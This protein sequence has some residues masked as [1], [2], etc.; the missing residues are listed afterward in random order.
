MKSP[1]PG[2][3]PYL[4]PFWSGVHTRLLV[5]L[6]NQLQGQLPSGLW[7]DVEETVVV[8]TLGNP[9]FHLRPDVAVF[10]AEPWNPDPGSGGT[11]VAVAEPL[12]IRD[13][14]ERT[15]RAIL[16]TDTTTG[17]QLVTAIELLSPAN[18]S[19][20]ENRAR[21]IA[22][23]NSYSAAGANLVEIDLLRGGEH[24]VSVPVGQL[25]LSKRHQPMVCVRRSLPLVWE[26]YP[27]SLR[28][29][30]P[31]FRVPLRRGDRDVI[32]QLQLAFDDNYQHGGYAKR[33]DYR[34]E[35]DPPFSVEDACWAQNLLGERGQP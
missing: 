20:T 29:P 7:A 33:V 1:F 16:V 4:E 2:L 15:E 31:S 21:Y 22:R 34:K 9:P 19:G 5:N 13:T 28:E 3:D 23:R 35:P 30:L 18:K 14:L 17:D 26:V 12:V 8:E 27:V 32:L 6:C 25:P 10:D 24:V 11:T